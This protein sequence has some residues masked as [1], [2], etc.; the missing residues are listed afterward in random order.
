MTSY[1]EAVRNRDMLAAAKVLIG[2]VFAYLSKDLPYQVMLTTNDS[3]RVAVYIHS[4]HRNK[5]LYWDYSTE[6]MIA[7]PTSFKR[8][9]GEFYAVAQATRQ[10]LMSAPVIGPEHE[11]LTT[12]RQKLKELLNG[13]TSRQNGLP[14]EVNE[15]S[16]TVKYEELHD[17][18]VMK[19]RSH[20]T[21]QSKLHD[22]FK[23]RDVSHVSGKELED[24]CQG[25]LVAH[26]KLAL[27]PNAH[28]G[29]IKV[30]EVPKGTTAY[31][32][33]TAWGSF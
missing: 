12:L 13:R 9:F 10:R 11:I 23:A 33:N 14:F 24:Y 19:F 20:K 5:R 31:A 29:M 3:I 28:P 4:P 7:S 15:Y 27:R 25:V 26:I 32:G 18:Y 2:E 30:P 17:K 1:S 6:K 16:I 8:D 22:L 21:H